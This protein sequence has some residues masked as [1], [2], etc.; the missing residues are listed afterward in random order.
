MKLQAGGF[1]Q[2]ANKHIAF[3]DPLCVHACASE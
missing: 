2:V 3:L 1:Y